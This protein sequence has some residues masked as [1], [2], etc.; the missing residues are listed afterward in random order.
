MLR[1][2]L[3]EEIQRAD[4]AEF[5]TRRAE[6]KMA[7]TAAEKDRILTE[8]NTLRENIEELKVSFRSPNSVVDPERLEDAM[9]DLTFCIP[10]TGW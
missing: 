2:R 10:P 1:E 8:R 3:A 4:H 5:E 6:E 9:S 7:T